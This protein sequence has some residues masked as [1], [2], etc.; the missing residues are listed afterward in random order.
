M[1]IQGEVQNGEW[2]ATLMVYTFKG[3]RVMFDCDIAPLVGKSVKGLNDL[4]KDN[5]ERLPNENY[6]S[7]LTWDEAKSLRSFET[8][9]KGGRRYPPHVYTELGIAILLGIMRNSQAKAASDNLLKAF[10]ELRKK[11]EP[12]LKQVHETGAYF[13]EGY[14]QKIYNEAVAEVG[15]SQWN[16]CQNVNQIYKRYPKYR[17]DVENGDNLLIARKHREKLDIDIT[18]AGIAVRSMRD[19]AIIEMCKTEKDTYEQWKE[20]KSLNP[21]KEE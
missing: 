3:R 8:T 21:K 17:S 18:K 4:A 14:N 16:E 9:S 2:K 10:V 1:T 5:K 11:T 13:P 12:I 6:M 7:I 15:I 19:G 20:D